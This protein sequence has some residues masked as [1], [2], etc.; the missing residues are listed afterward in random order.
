MHLAL[1]S[2]KFGHRRHEASLGIPRTNVP[3]ESD[4]SVATGVG[5]PTRD[6]G[7]RWWAVKSKVTQVKESG[8][9]GQTQV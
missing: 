5:M 9:A 7:N 4:P 3:F 6:D 8:Q 1:N 2:E